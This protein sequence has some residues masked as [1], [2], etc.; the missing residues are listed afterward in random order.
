MIF[1]TDIL[2]F[3]QRGNAK[4]AAVIDAASERYL[5][6]QSAMEVYQG[7]THKRQLDL[8]KRYLTDAGF[9][10]LPFSDNIGHRALIYIEQYTLSA[11]LFTGDAIIAATAVEHNMP[12]CT[13]N[14]KHF[15]AIA[16]L[17]LRLFRP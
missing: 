16:G 1:D 4:A 17:D 11:G 14:G 7:A 12:L 6:I 15:K 9:I 5:S 8:T 10:I 13:A 3:V 2:I